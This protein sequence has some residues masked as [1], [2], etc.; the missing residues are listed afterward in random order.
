M[1]LFLLLIF[2]L[3]FVANAGPSRNSCAY[4]LQV[5]AEEHCGPDGYPL[6]FGYRLCE[7]YLEAQPTMRPNVRRW[8][9]KIRYCLQNYLEDYRGTI[10][11]CSDLHRKAINSHV[12]CYLETGFCELGVLDQADILA[13][14][15]V[16]LLNLDV[17][18]L[19]VRVKAACER[20]KLIETAPEI[21]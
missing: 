7:K 9:P 12:G 2:C 10:R 5:E 11:D 4:Y 17:M 16:D 13:V 3:P 18:G 19:S 1:K 20:K 6:K 15:N 14:T 8:F 21:I